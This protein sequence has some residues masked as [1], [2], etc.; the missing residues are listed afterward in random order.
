MFPRSQGRSTIEKKITTDSRL[1][2]EN[3]VL[4]IVAPPPSPL[5]SRRVGTFCA[6]LVRHAGPVSGS[7]ISR[8]L[9]RFARP[10]RKMVPRMGGIVPRIPFFRTLVPEIFLPREFLFFFFVRLN[11]RNGKRWLSRS[12]RK[13]G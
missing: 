1:L 6:F 9:G 12:V 11:W 4:L 7:P 2:I 10:V 13:K 3:I 5:P 8:I